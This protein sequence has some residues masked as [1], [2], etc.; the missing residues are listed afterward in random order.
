MQISKQNPSDLY[1][2]GKGCIILV[3]P[4]YPLKEEVNEREELVTIRHGNSSV[5]IHKTANLSLLALLEKVDEEKKILLFDG[6]RSHQT[7]VDLYNDCL[8]EHG[9]EYTET[10]V[11]KPGCSEHES[12]LAIDLA[13]NEGKIDPI[14]PSFPK[15][16]ICEE[17]RQLAPE[18][19][20]IERYQE[21]KKDKTRIGAEEWH[22]R[23]V[24]LPHSLIIKEQ[25]LCLEEYIER[26]ANHNW[27][28]NPLI[29]KNWKIGFITSGQLESID[30]KEDLQISGNN[31]DGYI[32]A[33]RFDD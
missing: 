17:F 20:W 1:K 11:A 13:I 22:F 27:K 29:F 19:G 5:Q 28:L 21:K 8:K 15:T 7:Q 33:A 14:C 2:I 18:Y 23:Y 3:N 31:V 26:I 6:Y 25:D 4:F 30:Y 16:G 10:Y 32:V 12:G 9:K 24:G